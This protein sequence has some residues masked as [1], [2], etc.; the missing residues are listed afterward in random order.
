MHLRASFR[1]DRGTRICIWSSWV[2]IKSNVKKEECWWQHLWWILKHI[3]SLNT[4]CICKCNGC[5]LPLLTPL[6]VSSFIRYLYFRKSGGVQCIPESSILR[7]FDEAFQ[8]FIIVVVINIKGEIA[9]WVLFVLIQW[10]CFA[11]G[12]E[13]NYWSDTRQHKMYYITVNKAKHDVHLISFPFPHKSL[14]N[15]I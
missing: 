4:K 15:W 8:V 2:G 5:L 1:H 13:V 3:S 10:F 11:L 14:S 6:T 9:G 12:S 7:H